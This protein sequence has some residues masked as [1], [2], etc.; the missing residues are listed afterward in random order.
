MGLFQSSKYDYEEGFDAITS[1]HNA[2]AHFYG[3]YKITRAELINILNNRGNKN[4]V[5]GLGSA[6]NLAEIPSSDVSEAMQKLAALGNGKI[7]LNNNAFIQILTDQATKFSF[8]D[9]AKYTVVESSKNVV[10]A[11]VKV[12]NTL[13]SAGSS[14]LS[15][16]ENTFSLA[17][18]ALPI[19][20][21]GGIGFFVYNKSK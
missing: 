2:M 6:I 3:N 5:E 13:I 4:F 20:I 1:Y 7:P 10:N 16:I 21:I 19:I 15:A 17:K 11:S 12:G 9:A 18:Y 8:I 14:S